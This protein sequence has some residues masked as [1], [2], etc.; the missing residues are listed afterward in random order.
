MSMN[1]TARPSPNDARCLTLM[2]VPPQWVGR[3]DLDLSN[4]LTAQSLVV[5]LALQANC[6]RSWAAELVSIG[7]GV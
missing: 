7:P 5:K 4:A 2:M 1:R 6:P 3:H